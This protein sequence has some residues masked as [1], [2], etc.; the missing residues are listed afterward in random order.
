MC[1]LFT[2]HVVMFIILTYFRLILRVA[3]LVL[4]ERAVLRLSQ[5]RKRPNVVGPWR[6]IQCVTDRVKLITK[7]RLALTPTSALLYSLSPIL[8][9]VFTILLIASCPI[10]LTLSNYGY[11][12]LRIFCILSLLS[13]PFIL[14]R[15][16]YR[17]VYSVTRAVRVVGLIISYEI[18]LLLLILFFKGRIRDWNW[19]RTTN[20]NLSLTNFWSRI[21][22]TRPLM[23]LWLIELRRT[24][25][26]LAERESELVSGFNVEYRGWRFLFFFFSE[27][28]C[29]L[30][31]SL[32]FSLIILQNHSYFFISTSIL[33][34]LIFSLYVRSAL[35]RFRL[36][37]T[38]NFVWFRLT[39]W[40]MFIR[41]IIIIL[42][43]I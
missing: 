39:P 7:R 33:L 27:I 1:Q 16:S 25:F 29:L 23:I 40:V 35:P 2:T 24:P 8:L 15:F 4:T 6:V 10:P 43:Y 18:L 11:S 37:D 32:I 19:H 17:S 28:L 5:S 3:F 34:F 14:L 31:I 13:L 22:L 12:I 20:Y 26:D 21:F 36:I 38:Q 41:V 30:T 9:T 42:I